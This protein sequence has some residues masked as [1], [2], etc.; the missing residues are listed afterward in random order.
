V[1]SKQ[2]SL[3]TT[4]PPQH[5]SITPEHQPTHDFTLQAIME[6]QKSIG[7]NSAD[8]K[9]VKESFCQIEKRFDKVDGRF[10]VSDGKVS[11]LEKKVYIASGVVITIT[12]IVALLNAQWFRDFLLK[13]LSA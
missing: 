12:T 9:S 7:E 10:D 5:E 6:L 2:Q 4:S 3:K 1:G 8:L 11:S 13:A